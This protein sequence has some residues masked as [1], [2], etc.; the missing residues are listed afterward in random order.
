MLAHPTCPVIAS[1]L[2]TFNSEYKS[3]YLQITSKIDC[4]IY[5]EIIYNKFNY[6][7]NIKILNSSKK[8]IIFIIDVLTSPSLIK[9]TID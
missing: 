2:F 7:E 8:W 3:A 4:D 9:F 5:K 1:N 6:I